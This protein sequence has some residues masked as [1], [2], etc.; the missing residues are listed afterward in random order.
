MDDSVAWVADSVCAKA[1]GEESIKNCFVER[2]PSE[3][4]DLILNGADR[5]GHSLLDPRWRFAARMTCRWWRD[6]VAHPSTHDTQ[7]LLGLATVHDRV[8]SAHLVA[9]ASVSIRALA[10]LMGNATHCLRHTPGLFCA[11]QRAFLPPLGDDT[12]GHLLVAAIVSGSSTHRNWALACMASPDMLF[13]LLS[14][15]YDCSKT[16]KRPVGDTDA[17]DGRITTTTTTTTAA[18]TD[19]AEP[20]PRDLSVN[21]TESEKGHHVKQDFVWRNVDLAFPDHPHRG[22]GRMAQQSMVSLQARAYVAC[23]RTADVE[24]ALALGKRIGD[25][26]AEALCKRAIDDAIRRECSESILSAVRCGMNPPPP[27]R[28]GVDTAPED[29]KMATYA[30]CGIDMH[31]SPVLAWHVARRLFSSR[32][33][34]GDPAIM[35]MSRCIRTRPWYLHDTG[36]RGH[37]QRWVGHEADRCGRALLHAAIER[38]HAG[39]VAWVI[40]LYGA[41]HDRRFGPLALVRVADIIIASGCYGSFRSLLARYGFRPRWHHLI[42]ATGADAKRS[43]W[44]NKQMA[45]QLARLVEDWPIE[46]LSLRRGVPMVEILSG[47]M[48]FVTHPIREAMARIVAPHV[49]EVTLCYKYGLWHRSRRRMVHSIT[50]AED[51]TFDHTFKGAFLRHTRRT[52][53]GLPLIPTGDGAGVVATV[54]DADVCVDVAAVDADARVS[55][56]TLIQSCARLLGDPTDGL[57]LENSATQ[58]LQLPEHDGRDKT[59]GETPTDRQKRT[60]NA[61]RYMVQALWS[62]CRTAHRAGLVSRD[63]LAS[64]CAEIDGAFATDARSARGESGTCS[65]FERPK[66]WRA[67]VEMLRLLL[68][69]KVDP[70]I[71][72]PWIG[73]VAPISRSDLLPLWRHCTRLPF[74]GED[75]RLQRCAIVLVHLLGRAALIE[76]TVR[77]HPS[78]PDHD[79]CSSPQCKRRRLDGTRPPQHEPAAPACAGRD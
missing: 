56:H 75:T 65:K 53:A 64:V 70:A 78:P 62:V 17:A 60:P 74:S 13:S 47:H 58:W 5:R 72:R 36:H 26:S 42:I 55:A 77:T 1:E 68:G 16:T 39:M 28:E 24:A 66:Y 18:A 44:R 4:W 7:R 37:Q 3:L 51:A 27:P 57:K 63:L 6:L 41:T 48:P 76:Q 49:H 9:A 40:G 22:L 20:A 61:F 15:L 50:H 34:R 29:C 54:V 10:I 73:V 33:D 38:Q 79:S 71:W 21:E 52:L 45:R 67:S 11:F 14:A 12:S 30:W 32:R 19:A 2:L 43:S 59:A 31:G 23:T 35:A 46:F 8:S 69:L 25:A